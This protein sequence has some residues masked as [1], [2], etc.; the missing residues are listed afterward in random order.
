MALPRESNYDLMARRVRKDFLACDQGRMIEKFHLRHDG[1]YLYVPFCGRDYRIDRKTGAVEGSGDGFRT[2]SPGDYNEVM[3]LYD[4]LSRTGGACRPAGRFAPIHSLPGTGY[5]ASVGSDLFA[6]AAAAFAGRT[7]DLA[8]ACRALGG[9]PEGRG[10]AAFRLMV[11]PFLPVLFRF[12]DADEE[13]PA[14]VQLLWDENTLNFVFFETT[15]FIAAH[16]LSRLREE[17][18]RTFPGNGGTPC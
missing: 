7:G 18:D 14:S 5:T 15:F 8:R 9:V 10:D 12:Y 6:P 11:F 17:M 16:L 13:F 3:A 1:A 2:A 4:A